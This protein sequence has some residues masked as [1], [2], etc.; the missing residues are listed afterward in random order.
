MLNPRKKKMV[1]K[2]SIYGKENSVPF[3][4]V[5]HEAPLHGMHHST[6]LPHS[7]SSSQVSIPAEG[8]VRGAQ[9]VQRAGSCPAPCLRHTS[10]SHPTFFPQ[11]K[12]MGPHPA[13]PL[14]GFT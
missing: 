11:E 14:H 4:F 3:C 5:G 13:V 7:Y 8:W 2:I 9:P 10:A 6:L 1:W 12:P